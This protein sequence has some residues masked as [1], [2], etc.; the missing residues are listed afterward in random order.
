MSLKAAL[1]AAAMALAAAAALAHDYKAGAIEIDHPWARATP[2]GATV[3]AGYLKLTN[4]GSTPDRLVGASA[5]VSPRVEVHEM[6][7][8]NGVM[9]MRPL[10]DG[11]ELKPGETVELKPGA[12][13]LMMLDLKQQLQKG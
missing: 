1:I 4:T 12:L 13:H 10:K 5:A 2:R 6:A 3:A 8:V 9:Q 11:L 7:T